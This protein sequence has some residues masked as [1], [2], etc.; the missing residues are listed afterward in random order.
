MLTGIL[1]MRHGVVDDG[2]GL[3][4]DWTTLAEVLDQAGYRTG[5][6]VTSFFVGRT[7]GLDQ[8]M[9]RF[10]E[11]G[12]TTKKRNL[13]ATV[14]AQE[15]LEEAL[16]FLGE[17]PGR[18]HFLFLHLYDVHV[19]YGAP[20]PWDRQFDR[21][22]TSDD[23]IYRNY[24]HHL[25]NPV[26]PEQLT[27]QIAQYDE[28]IAYVDD[29]LR[30]LDKAFDDAGREV[31]WVVTSDH[32]EEFGERGSWGHAH[33][34]FAEQ[35]RVPL[36]FAGPG[37]ATGTIHETVGTQDIAPTLA[38]LAGTSLDADGLSLVAALRGTEPTARAF[39]G[40]TSRFD[41][42]RLGLW[43]D[44]LRLDWNAATNAW[45]LYADPE[46][47]TDL[48]ATLP[49]K[50]KLLQRALGALL[51]AQWVCEPGRIRTSGQFVI[52]GTP[53][54]SEIELASTT[55][56]SVVPVDARIWHEGKGPWS[57]SHLPPVNAKIRHR[58]QGTDAT[59][60]TAQDRARLEAL[61]YIQ[62]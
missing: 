60:L 23:L 4:S 16:A 53:V 57:P 25:E 13:E 47:A 26:P 52:A 46:E 31:I 42:N 11:F 17:A 5:A 10:E 54:G 21:P 62:Q 1:P 48:S 2:Q 32:G 51:T 40:D 33:T 34:L 41:T 27:H 37:V 36:I 30:K 12:I 7:F 8:G 14:D 19:P 49:D 29:Q 35:L 24:F 43:Q 50:R 9:A 22:G 18:S 6:F 39:I 45:S 59:V 15:V 28:E 38:E 20:A 55:A 56:V 44:G 3:G 61:G 58:G